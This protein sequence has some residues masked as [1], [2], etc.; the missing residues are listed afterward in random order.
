MRDKGLSELNIRFGVRFGMGIAI[1]ISMNTKGT[2]NDRRYGHGAQM[3][4]INRKQTAIRKRLLK[5]E[6]PETSK[7]LCEL[8]DSLYNTHMTERLHPS[9]E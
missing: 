1:D 8:Y 6:T 4:R 3:S 9:H 7:K 5:G 2:D